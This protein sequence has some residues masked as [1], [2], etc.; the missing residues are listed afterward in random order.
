MSFSVHRPSLH[1]AYFLSGASALV[2]Q[3]LW[4]RQLGLVF[5]TT[6][7]GMACVLGAFMGGLALGSM[8][9]ARFGDRLAS[10]L[11]AYGLAELGVAASALAVPSLQAAAQVLFRWAVPAEASPL[12]V[13]AVQLPLSGL[14]LLVPTTLMGTT[15]PLLSRLAVRSTD[16]RAQD[17]GTLY[18]VN[19]LGSVAGAVVAGFWALETLGLR[20]TLYLGVAGSLLVGVW[21]LLAA[22]AWPRAQPRTEGE[23]PAVEAATRSLVLVAAAFSGALSL[24]SE[25]V[26]TRLA[27]LVAL[28]TTYVY[29]TVLAVVIAGLGLGSL[30][31]TRAADRSPAPLRTFALLQASAGACALAVLPVLF[32]VVRLW[33]RVLST[34]LAHQGWLAV[35]F[36]LL[37]A[38]S[39]LLVGGAFP[40][41]I[42]A[43]TVPDG[44]LG[45]AV[46]RLYAWNT[47]GAIVGSLLAGFVLLPRLGAVASSQ[48]IG[49]LWLVLGFWLLRDCATPRRQVV[50]LAAAALVAGGLSASCSVDDL[51]RPRLPEGARVLEVSE[52][53]TSTVMVAEQ[54]SPPIR[55]IW[56]QSSWVAGSAGL[57]RLLGH[58]PML[59]AAGV[60]RVAGIAFGTGQSFGATSLY[61]PRTL[62]CIDLDAEVV[63]LGGRWFGEV[64][65]HLLDLPATRVFIQDGR[66][67]LSRVREPYDVIVMEPLQPWSAGAVNLYTLESYRTARSALRDGGTLVQWL[68]LGDLSESMVRS[69][70]ATFVAAFPQTIVFLPSNLEPLLVGIAGDGPVPLS[71]IQERLRIPE[72]G[73]DL[74]ESSVSD[75]EDLLS[76]VIGGPSD[77]RAFGAGAP[78]LTDDRP[79][80]E[81]AS[82]KTRGNQ[83][84][85]NVKA[86]LDACR[87]PLE[88]YE[89]AETLSQELRDCRAS[90][91]LIDALVNAK[92]SKGATAAQDFL[93]AARSAPGLSRALEYARTATATQAQTLL[94]RGQVDEACSLF[95]VHL[96][97]DPGAGNLWLNLGLA[98][99]RGGRV[100]AARRTLARALE[101]PAS[102][103]AAQ[104]ALRLLE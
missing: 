1:V 100:D 9:G 6:T 7:A 35:G 31:A 104:D 29:S 44:S 37:F 75:A 50:G 40:F 49:A 61:Q 10:P 60:D 91:G 88:A 47:A 66:S 34:D 102:R 36:G 80:M 4:V 58:L 86:L 72:V 23:R 83:T 20:G 79:V 101:D 93:A 15:L 52:G 51:Y 81:F 5:G 84:F 67:F 28:T 45:S 96:A 92:R 70:V 85:R 14:V 17:V 8:L 3:V 55:R 69:V 77:A 18:A 87:Q 43:G 48:V 30:L 76:M 94:A 65:R 98:Q 2:Y 99:A 64:N 103:P 13:L 38:P 24:G 68:P 41:L 95:E 97:A 33:P 46:G 12:V 53:S 42:R 71:R 54:G 57:H 19:T 90:R 78:L 89:G 32:G 74:R 11:R 39:V 16:S 82:P 27:G 56:I 22:P 62:D 73:K 21:G 63:V 25:V 59:H 26:W